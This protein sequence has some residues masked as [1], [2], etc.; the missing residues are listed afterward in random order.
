[1]EIYFTEPTISDS[2]KNL[3]E[4]IFHY[5]NSVLH[6]E[7]ICILHFI[8]YLPAYYQSHAYFKQT[9][10]RT[11]HFVVSTHA[12][13]CIYTYLTNK[14]EIS[15]LANMFAGNPGWNVMDE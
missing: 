13:L 8:S 6:V 7:K 5:L 1:M 14:I 9:H 2:L 4:I 3:N 15:S 10:L 11:V 12:S